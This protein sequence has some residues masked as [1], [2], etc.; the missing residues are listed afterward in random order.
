[1]REDT[2]HMSCGVPPSVSRGADTSARSIIRARVRHDAPFRARAAAQ[3]S[4]NCGRR[5]QSARDRLARLCNGA[6]VLPSIVGLAFGLMAHTAWFG[7]CEWLLRLPAHISPPSSRPNAPAP[8]RVAPAAQAP[9]AVEKA[10]TAFVQVPILATFD[11]T[12]DIRTIRLARPEGFDFK[13]GQFLTV[14]DHGGREGAG[15]LLLDQLGPGVRGL[16][17][18]L[19]QAA[20]HRVECPARDGAA[21]RDAVDQEA[22]RRVQIPVRRRSSD[23]A[24]GGRR[25]HHAA[26]EHAAPRGRGR[27][28]AS[29]H[30]AV[31]AREEADFAFRDELASISGVT[32]RRGS[33]WRRAGRRSSLTCIRAASTRRSAIGGAGRRALDLPYLRSGGR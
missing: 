9:P 8:P 10:A 12:A 21:G 28:G 25:R 18:S 16:P 5:L 19:G 2:R 14:R 1:M 31:R 33:F 6:L 15:P 30:A 32:R 4:P 29:G 27:A 26:D 3:P 23:R 22:E 17:R 13:A 24:A 11:E 20:G 7:I